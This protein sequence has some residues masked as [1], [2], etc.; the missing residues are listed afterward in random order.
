M[1]ERPLWAPWRIEYVTGPK[2]GECIFCAAAAGTD[3]DPAHQPID[4]GEHCLTLMNAFPYAPG[5]VM[6][7]PFRHVGMLEDLNA[8]EMLET[9]RL[10]QR[11]VLAIRAVMSPDGFNVGLNLG[12]VAGAGFED[13]LHLHV[14]PRWNGDTNFMP[15]LAD[16]D[17]IPQAL[18]ATRTLL[19]DAITKLT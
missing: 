9:M 19:A 14:V 4:R 1:S 16:T 3:P 18:E 17:V 6:V 13:H 8:D 12:K 15:V 7:A 10:A 2:D 11:A 5:H